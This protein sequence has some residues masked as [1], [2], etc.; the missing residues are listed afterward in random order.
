MQALGVFV[1]HVHF[2]R[3]FF[4]SAMLQNFDANEYSWKSDKLTSV[5]FTDHF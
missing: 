1:Y 3:F 4:N 2:K 5:V